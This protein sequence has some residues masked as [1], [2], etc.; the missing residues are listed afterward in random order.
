[1][2]FAL[3]LIAQQ[4]C[5]VEGHSGMDPC[6]TAALDAMVKAL[7]AGS[8]VLEIGFNCGHSSWAMLD[9]RPDVEVLSF[10]I[11]EHDYVI[12]AAAA[13]R[14]NFPRRHLLVVGDSTKTL[15]SVHGTFDLFFIDGCHEY[16]VSKQDL[17]NSLALARTT[18]IIVL[19]DVMLET[20]A[21][22]LPSWAVGPT[23]LWREYIA[24]GLITQVGAVDRFAVTGMHGWAFGYPVAN[25]HRCG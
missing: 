15:P 21:E 16:D 18:D 1:M 9:A 14:A 11:A 7:P 8:R 13:V 24:R 6:E 22:A 5:N 3:D 12:S 2:P 17:D 20:A 25:G 10:D 19:D 4:Y 23:R